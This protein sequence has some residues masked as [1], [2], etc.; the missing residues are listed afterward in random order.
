SSSSSPSP[1]LPPPPS[2]SPSSPPQSR[3][4]LDPRPPT[5][6]P[7][8]TAD[9]FKIV[10]V[11]DHECG[12]TSFVLTYTDN[13]RFPRNT[14]LTTAFIP[15]NRVTVRVDGVPYVV[16][17]C[18]TRGEDRYDHLRPLNYVDAAVFV[19]CFALDSPESLDH[20]T[21]KWLPEI[22]RHCRC[23][24]LVLLGCKR[25][26]RDELASGND[27]EVYV[28]TNLGDAIRRKIR[29][30]QYWETSARN[31]DGVLQFF[32]AVAQLAATSCQKECKCESTSR[33]ARF[34]QR[35]CCCVVS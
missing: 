26:I 34:L 19:L 3:R 9:P 21:S 28:P 33:P 23:R 25:D 32:Q 20:V 12:K 14:A 13:G 11:G 15:G 16:W 7:K 5:T 2:P 18:D 27:G 31:Y 1:S 17:P 6:L 30:V 35:A 4:H 8:M 24:P 22:R 29:A 10:F